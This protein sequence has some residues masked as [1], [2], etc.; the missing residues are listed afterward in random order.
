[1]N[2]L[3]LTLLIITGCLVGA[4]SFQKE[5]TGKTT[6]QKVDPSVT[7]DDYALYY[8]L[9]RTVL[10]IEVVLDKKIVKPGPF[11][12]HAERLLGLKGVPVEESVSYSIAEIRVSSHPEKDPSQGYLIRTTGPSFGSHISLTADGLIRGINIPINTELSVS[13]VIS[14]DLR[15]KKFDEPEYPDL[16]LR[17]NFEPL[18]DTIFRIVRTDTSFMRLPLVV[19]VKGQK[20]LLNQ[21]EEA[22]EVLMKIRTSRFSL[23]NG[24]FIDKQESL[25]FPEGGAFEVIIRELDR[26]E[27]DYLSLFAGRT[28][29][30]R[31]TVKFSIVPEGTGLTETKTL[32]VF[33]T[34]S[35]IEAPESTNG[36]PVVLELSRQG[37]NPVDQ[38]QWAPDDPKKPREAGMA[39]R[40]PELVRVEILESGS[41]LFAR[42][43]LIAQFGR[44]DFIPASVLQ[45]PETAIEFYA[46]YGSVK[47][48]FRR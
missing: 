29:N 18:P 44:I 41:G 35:G 13:Q 9:P 11:A 37:T 23:L 10:D 7:L 32:F 17:K 31:E 3:T 46:T 15:E 40:I 24:E 14:S 27:F 36:I 8:S 33:S 34:Q 16:T 25:P 39:Y 42:D 43:M 28:Q 20:S 6:V 1:M 38:I 19:E 12:V 5:I 30:E 22:A 48:I 4:C 45:D 47:N 21:A 2:K 26:M